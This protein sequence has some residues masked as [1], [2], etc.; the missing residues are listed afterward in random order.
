[1]YVT[2]FQNCKQLITDMKMRIKGYRDEN[3]YVESENVERK[4]TPKER[5]GVNCVERWK[6]NK[7]QIRIE[8][9]AITETKQQTEEQRK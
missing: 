7:V 3:V 4:E 6:K 5:K 9:I 8:M 2:E 1:M